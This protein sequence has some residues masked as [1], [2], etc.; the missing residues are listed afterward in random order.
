[1]VLPERAE[2]KVLNPVGVHIFSLLDG[3]HTVADIA[4]ALCQEFEVDPDQAV[5]DVVEFVAELGRHGMLADFSAGE[6]GAVH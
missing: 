2:V 4:D 3:E 6:T 5:R 1:V